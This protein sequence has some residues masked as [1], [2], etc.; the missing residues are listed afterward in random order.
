MRTRI[1]MP[2]EGVLESLQNCH[3]DVVQRLVDSVVFANQDR[4][5]RWQVGSWGESVWFALF[6]GMYYTNGLLPNDYSLLI[7]RDIARAADAEL[8]E[9]HE[10]SYS[11]KS[12]FLTR[13]HFQDNDVEQVL[14]SFG[15]AHEAALEHVARRGGARREPHRPDMWS[16]LALVSS[17]LPTYPTRN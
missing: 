5:H 2:H 9:R 10:W 7:S 3:Q 15:A 1:V 6:V 16:A 14:T 8:L 11:F 13:I 12:S 17:S 4:P